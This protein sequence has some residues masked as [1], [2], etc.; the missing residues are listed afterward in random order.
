MNPT[1]L[2]LVLAAAFLHA[3][4]NLMVKR[5]EQRLAFFMLALACGSLIFSPALWIK[6]SIPPAIW[7]YAIA[8]GL[9]EALYIVFLVNAYRLADFSLVYPVGRGAAPAFLAL[10][11]F[12]FLGERQAPLGLAG[13]GLIVLGLVVIGGYPLFRD[14]RLDK[15]GLRSIFLSLGVALMISIYSVIDGAAVKIMEP[16]GYTVLILAL[17]AV[18]LLPMTLLQVRPA[19]ITVLWKAEYKRIIAGGFLMVF[20]Y[21]LVLWAYS[22]GA[23]SYAGAVRESSVVLAALAGWLWLGEE[24][25]RARLAGAI[26]IF[27]GI[28][29]IAFS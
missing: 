1:A 8:S 18:F 22:F 14:R 21:L 20:T 24:Y 28:L 9:L 26:L 7:H 13:I 10:W 4:W 16:A 29:A 27:F 17:S 23:V 2:L 12:L 6:L 19:A 5:M 11:S 3:G 25:G 15:N